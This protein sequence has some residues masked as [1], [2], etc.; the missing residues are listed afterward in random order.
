MEYIGDAG[1]T[2]GGCATQDSTATLGAAD[3]TPTTNTCTNNSAANINEAAA[4]LPPQ[5][6]FTFQFWLGAASRQRI[7]WAYM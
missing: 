2:D 4:I 5:P 3:V 6:E 7:G 1:Y